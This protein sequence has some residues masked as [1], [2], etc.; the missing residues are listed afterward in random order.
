MGEWTLKRF[1]ANAE[2]TLGE[3]LY[4]GDSYCWTCED[5]IRAVKRDGET[6]IPAGRYLV[7]LTVS[8]RAKRG[9]LW[10]PWPD[11]KLPLLV[12]VPGFAGIRIHSGN[13]AANTEG[14]ILVGLDRLPNGV[15]TS[16]PALRRLMDDMKFPTY[17]TIINPG[18]NP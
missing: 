5:A 11:F 13:N 18:G 3:L 12:N 9:G 4:D 14:C 2:R 16:R 8:P 17:I 15:G 7:Q 1:D 10:T 6:A